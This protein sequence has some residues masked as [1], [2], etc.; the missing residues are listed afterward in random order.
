MKIE[1]EKLLCKECPYVANSFINLEQHYVHWHG[2]DSVYVY[3]KLSV[4]KKIILYIME[5]LRKY[6]VKN[7]Q[8]KNKNC[9][10][11]KK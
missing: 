3:Q 11:T 1:S 10:T 5:K 6:E 4:Y 7:E 2:L 8:N 9:I